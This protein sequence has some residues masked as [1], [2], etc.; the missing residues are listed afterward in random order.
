MS[1]E[2]EPEPD[3]QWQIERISPVIKLELTEGHAV[4]MTYA[5]TR[6][7]LFREPYALMNHLFYTKPDRMSGMYVF[8]GQAL[9]EEFFTKQ[10]PQCHEPYPSDG[11][12][13]AFRTWERRN[14]DAELEG[15]Q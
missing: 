8:V 14:L 5:N 2:Q 4:D 12:I 13:L 9:L 3:D 15:L 7:F 1:V 11:D 6:M 10:Y